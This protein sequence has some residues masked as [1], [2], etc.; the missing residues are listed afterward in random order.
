PAQQEFKRLV[1]KY[2]KRHPGWKITHAFLELAEPSI[3]QA[4]E[5]LAATSKE[6]QVL[7]LFLFGAKHVRK[8]IPEILAAFRKTHPKVKIKLAKP[9]GADS[10]LLDI[11]DQRLHAISP[12]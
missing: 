5:S 3:P 7:P 12:K 2:R 4:L 11:L 6:I 8:H 10:Q 9:L 1:G